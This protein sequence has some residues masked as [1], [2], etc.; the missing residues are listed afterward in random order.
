MR[1]NIRFQFVSDT[2]PDGAALLDCHGLSPCALL[3]WCCT[4][5]SPTHV[6][7]IIR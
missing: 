7:V 2:I 1:E 6:G 3:S 4:S 5:T